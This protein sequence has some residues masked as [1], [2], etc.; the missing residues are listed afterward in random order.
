[1]NRRHWIHSAG[2]C[3]I[4]APMLLGNQL[5]AQTQPN[6]LPLFRY[7]LNTST[8]RGQ[9]LSL[10]ELIGIT[11]DAG[12]DGIELWIREIEGYLASGGDLHDLGKRIQD[13]GLTVENAIGFAP[14]LVNDPIQRAQGL[15]QL[16]REMEMLAAIGG[17]RIATPPAGMRVED[18]VD[19]E[20]MGHR[21]AEV[22]ELGRQTG[23]MPQ[24]EFWGA[25]DVLFQ[26]GQLV[27]VAAAAN[28]PDARLLPDVYHLFR[29]G[30]GFDGL[31]LI[32]G[33]AIEI[34]HV[35]DY[36]ASP[37]RESQKDSDRVFPGDGV[38][39]LKTILADLKHMGGNKV[40]S[41]EL[42]NPDYWKRDALEVA[43]TGLM[44]MRQAVVQ[45]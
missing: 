1:M 39:P 8:I 24:L 35:N 4:T 37:A 45:S 27:H 28:D 9:K 10:P 17:K 6:N 2:L 43:K 21:Y 41:L 16:K 20:A 19:Y 22:L 14:V 31:K 7:C 30:S 36:P 26:L 25:S 34:F 32:A 13:S 42:F 11:A 44:K 38:A 40:L 15:E 23:V 29:G 12:Y 18:G 33:S 5:E 3:G